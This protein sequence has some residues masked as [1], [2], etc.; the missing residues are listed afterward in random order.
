LRLAQ[1]SQEFGGK[2]LIMRIIL[3]SSPE[4]EV[5]AR[6][7]Q[8][9]QLEAEFVVDRDGQV[10]YRHPWDSRPWFAGP[11]V[12]AFREAAVAWNR[13]CDEAPEGYTD[14]EQQE[15][16][17]RLRAELSRIGILSARSDNLWMSLVEQAQDGLL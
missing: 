15:A 1:A 12:A 9:G 14:E 4:G 2:D 17:G 10:F 13:Y 8:L 7:D 3:L 5:I 6:E 11:T 16:V